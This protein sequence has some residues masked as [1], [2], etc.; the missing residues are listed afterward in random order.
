MAARVLETTQSER[1]YSLMLE[2][3]GL[4]IRHRDEIARALGDGGPGSRRTP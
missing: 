2:L 4:M 3:L 1:F